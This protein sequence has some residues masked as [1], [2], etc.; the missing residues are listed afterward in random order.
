MLPDCVPVTQ[1]SHLGDL[2]EQYLAG[3][4]IV[5]LQRLLTLDFITK[6]TILNVEKVT[7][8]AWEH[9]PRPSLLHTLKASSVTSSELH[10]IANLNFK[11]Q[12]VVSSL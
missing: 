3:K 6:L 12:S 5:S 11:Q 7:C 1:G 4:R 2:E 10:V 9:S 8:M